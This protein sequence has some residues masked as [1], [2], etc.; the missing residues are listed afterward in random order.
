MRGCGEQSVVRLRGC[1]WF[2]WITAGASNVV[3]L[4]ADTGIAE[5]LISADEAWVL[6]SEIEAQR[7]RDE[8]LPAGFGLHGGR[9]SEPQEREQFT[10]DLSG[11]G[12]VLS[13]QPAAGETVLPSSIAE[14]KYTLMPAEIERYREVGA[15]ASQAMTDVLSVAQPG[16]TEHELAGAGAEAL[17]SRGLHPA[18]TLAAGERRLPR[19]RHPTP[20]AAPLGKIAMLVFCAR[21]FGL[22]ANLTRF[23]AFGAIGREVAER[24]ASVREIEADALAQSRPGNTLDSVYRTLADSYSAHGFP[25]AIDQHH[26]GGSTGYRSREIVATSTTRLQLHESMALAWN[27]SI[28]GA[29]IED[30]FLI[31]AQGPENLTYDERWPHQSVRGI[32]R[33][34]VLQR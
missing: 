6:T 12:K 18:L 13:D 9:W 33:P 2:S 22:Y 7:L 16:W 25:D 14:L 8:E 30:T 34:L 10:A 29:K 11:A 3:L 28:V 27:P 32:A 20:T 1:D 5:V 19:Y 4:A 31:T 24:H 23:V 21:G 15:L 17:W 26:Q